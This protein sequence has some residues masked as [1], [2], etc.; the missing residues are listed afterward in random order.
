MEDLF[1]SAHFLE[2]AGAHDGDARGDL[3]HYGQAVRDEDVGKGKF[4]LDFL[5]PARSI[6]SEMHPSP[7][8]LPPLT[9]APGGSKPISASDNMVLPLPDS[10]TSPRD[11]PLLMRRDTSFTG[12][13]HPAAVGSSTVNPR[14]SSRGSITLMI[15]T[16]LI[17]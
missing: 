17:F 14:T 11:S 4:A 10:P 2:L 9:R 12:R 16:K 6:S 5:R 7:G 3:G 1:G 8:R 13:T 15:R